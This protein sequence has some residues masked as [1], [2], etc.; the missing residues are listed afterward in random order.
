MQICLT[1][2]LIRYLHLITLPPPIL[3]CMTPTATRDETLAKTGIV[4]LQPNLSI[5][6]SPGPDKIPKGFLN[7]CA[8]HITGHLYI[9]AHPTIFLNTVL[10]QVSGNVMDTDS[11]SDRCSASYTTALLD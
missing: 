7:I 10:S 9:Q 6:K 4:L 1:V 5:E 3:I 2:I 8:E 11:L